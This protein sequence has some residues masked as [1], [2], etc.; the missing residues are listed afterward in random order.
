MRNAYKISV[1]KLEGTR[2]L[3]KPRRK[4]DDN[5]KMDLK[6]IVYEGID[7]IYLARNRIQWRFLV[8]TVC[9]FRF[10]KRRAIS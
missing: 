6:E 8:N 9:T 3:G 10:H 1:E 4:W 7:W 5:I 2:P